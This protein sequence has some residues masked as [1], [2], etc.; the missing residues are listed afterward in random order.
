MHELSLIGEL[1]NILDESAR[2]NGIVRIGKVVLVVGESHQALPEALAT[3]F[4]VLTA[5]TLAEGAVLEVTPVDLALRCEECGHEYGGREWPAPCPACGCFRRTLVRG[6]ELY[7]D[8]YEGE[9]EAD[10]SCG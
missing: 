4:A 5:D 6:D 1:V 7:V 8:Y 10:L 3:A 2:E 9:T